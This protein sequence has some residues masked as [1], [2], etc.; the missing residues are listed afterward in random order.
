M[1]TVAPQPYLPTFKKYHYVI[2][3]NQVQARP[4]LSAKITECVSLW[5]YVENEIGGL[6]GILLETESQAAQAVF[7]V[8]RR[9]SNQR[10]AI[11]AAANQR[12]NGNDLHAYKALIAE[13]GSLETQ[14]NSLVHGCFGIC[15]ENDDLLFV[16]A[17]EHHMLW[18][19]DILSKHKRKL[20]IAEPHRGLQERLTV[21][22]LKD[23]ESSSFQH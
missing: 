8:L 10:A 12:L 17:L 15:P 5:S 18:Q 11:D 14:R 7:T 6:F 4:L 1:T 16:I 22:R 9:W 23:L 3:A 19:T 2:G 21:Y 20:P 13:Y